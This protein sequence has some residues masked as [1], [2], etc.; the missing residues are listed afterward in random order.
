LVIGCGG[1]YL[2][3]NVGKP[4]YTQIPAGAEMYPQTF[5]DRP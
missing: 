4:M 3:R 1:N 2:R 5:V